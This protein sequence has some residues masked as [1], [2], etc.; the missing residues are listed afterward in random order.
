M[1][2]RRKVREIVP[3]EPINYEAKRRRGH[4]ERT[5][6]VAAEQKPR[7]EKLPEDR[8]GRVEKVIFRC[9]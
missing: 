2:N 9:I 6:G 7:G 4:Q 5:A 8:G 3:T 1:P